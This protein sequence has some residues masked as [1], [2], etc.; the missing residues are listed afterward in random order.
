MGMFA[1][2]MILDHLGLTPHFRVLLEGL[3]QGHLLRLMETF[4]SIL[5]PY[6]Q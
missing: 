6:G 1:D 4:I 3:K 2:I 5:G